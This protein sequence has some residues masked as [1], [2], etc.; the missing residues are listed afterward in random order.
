MWFGEDIAARIVKWMEDNIS[1]SSHILD[2]GCGNGMLLVQLSS[3]GYLNLDGI[4][5]SPDAITLAREVAL[6][7]K[8]NINYDVG[9]ILKGL[10]NDKQYDVV[11]DKGTYDAVSLSNEAKINSELYIRNVHKLLKEDGLLEGAFLAPLYQQAFKYF[12][13]TYGLEALVERDHDNNKFK[14][15]IYRYLYTGKGLQAVGVNFDTYEIA[16]EGNTRKSRSTRSA[17]LKARLLQHK[18][19]AR[20]FSMSDS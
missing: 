10:S 20:R 13:D 2:V 11:L 4:D 3:S 12:R 19:A 8:T 6:H 18:R 17:M 1:V 9:D 7:Y 14:F 15:R 5:Y 16:Q